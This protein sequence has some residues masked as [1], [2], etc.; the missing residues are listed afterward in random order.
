MEENNL[1]NAKNLFQEGLKYLQQ[2]NYEIAEKKFI[3]SLK[4]APGRLSIIHNLISIYINTNQ[5]DK[6]RYLL[7]QNKNLNE[8]KEIL[9]GQAFSSYFENHFELSINICKKIIKFEQFKFSIQDLL[10]SNYKKQK[11]FLDALKIYKLQLKQNRCNLPFYNIGCL[12]LDLG[13]TKTA[14]Y[15]FNKSKEIK[16]DDYTNL[17]NLS[18]CKLKLKDFKNGFLL[19]ENR[20][21]KKNDAVKKKFSQIASPSSLNEI[22][23]KKILIWDEQGLGDTIQFSRFVIDLLK[24]SKNIT[25]VVNSKLCKIL[26]N[27]DEKIQVYDYNKI[28][29]SKFDFQIPLCSLPK[30]LKIEKV[31]DINFYKLNV[32]FDKTINFNLDPKNYNIG[33]SWSGNSKYFLDQYRSISFANFKNILNFKEINYYKLSKDKKEDEAAEIDSFTNLSDMGD[34]SL[35]EISNLMNSLD[36][37]ISSDTSIIHLAGILNIKSVLLLNYNSDWRWFDDSKNTIWYPSVKILKQNKF[38]DWTNVFD[39]LEQILKNYIYDK[40]KG[41]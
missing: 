20:L 32:V 23:D 10:A 1:E 6:L 4:F 37:V 16:V 5:K 35:Y 17:N 9:Y 36:L 38:D 19:Y 41:Q 34:K 8:E 15:Y 26:N 7:E 12:F 28:D 40:K 31:E 18:L 2:E 25:F 27:L 22:K 11:K 39:E 14:H 21:K 3:D 29:E 13:R 30:F 24:Y 33:L